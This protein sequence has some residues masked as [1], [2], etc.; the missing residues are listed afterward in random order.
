MFN[1]GSPTLVVS[2]YL[3]DENAADGK[4]LNIVGRPS[5]L[6]SWL[7]TLMKINPQT[8]LELQNDR[9]SVSLS[10]LSGE[11]HTVVPLD[12]I[13]ITKCGFSKK[14]RWLV[15]GIATLLGG[16]SAGD[17]GVFMMA[18][19]LS[20][21]FLVLYFFSNRMFLSVTAGGESVVIEYKKS[22]VEGVKVDLDRTLAAIEVLN[23][24]VL[25]MRAD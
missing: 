14:L 4:Y 6:M 8:N 25:A 13:D 7:L 11:S 3:V 19:L 16:V 15:L 21:V 24:R 20:A 18:L 22:V 10:Q 23:G 1:L 17:G 9:L 12:A 5:G 2:K